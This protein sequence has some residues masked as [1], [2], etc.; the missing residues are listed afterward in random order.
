M[1]ITP[2]IPHMLKRCFP[3][4][5]RGSTTSRRTIRNI[6]RPDLVGPL[7]RNA[8][9]QIRIDCRPARWDA[10]ARP[11][12]QRLNAHP[13][14]QSPHVPPANLVSL[15]LQPVGELARPV[16]RQLQVQFVDP[17]HQ[18]QIPIRQ[19]SRAVVHARATEIEKLSL[20]LREADTSR[21]CYAPSARLPSRARCR[22]DR[23]PP[24]RSCARSRHGR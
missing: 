7:D 15:A 11:S 9:E 5:R 20:A 3:S 4:M 19:R 6:A 16:E 13:A 2:C 1:F 8:R 23:A 24:P 17:P 12:V 14:H 10:G 18:H 22:S 21:R